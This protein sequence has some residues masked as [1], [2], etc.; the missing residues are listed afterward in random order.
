MK[1]GI[2]PFSNMKNGKEMFDPGF[3]KKERFKKI[4]KSIFESIQKSMIE[5]QNSMFERFTPSMIDF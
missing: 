4:K 2:P 3:F 5:V 1:N